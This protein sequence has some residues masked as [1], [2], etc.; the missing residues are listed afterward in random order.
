MSTVQATNLKHGSSA[1]NN[2]VLDASG[3]AAF[4]AA[5][6]VAGNATITGTL[7]AN[8]VAGSVYPLVLGT[9]QTASGAN[10]D[11]TG[12]PSWARR[13]TV[14]FNGVSTNGTAR[15]R[16]QLGSSAGFVTTGYTGANTVF[17]A[18]TLSTNTQTAGFELNSAAATN[19]HDGSIQ[20]F[21]FSSSSNLWVANGGFARSDNTYI[22]YGNVTLPGTLDRVR[23]TTVG[24]TDTFDA[25]S[26]NL[27][28]E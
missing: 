20:F 17:G 13:V 26:I 16:F 4:A 1:S 12:I 2:I 24:G 11:F 15:Y 25:G 3:N 6:T 22:V 8:G 19:T 5:V 7:Q 27:L 14:M 18:S 9:A 10:V 23:I 21:L 28:W